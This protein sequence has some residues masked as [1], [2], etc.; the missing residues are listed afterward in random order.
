M[1]AAVW[2]LFGGF[3]VEGLD[4]YTALRRRCCWP[5]R[6][7]GPEAGPVA[8][9]VAETIRL[10]IGGGLAWA[11]ADSGQITSPIGA[12]AVG[13]AAP[14][15]VERLT[16]AVPLDDPAAIGSQQD[17]ISSAP[18][19]TSIRHANSVDSKDPPLPVRAAE[20]SQIQE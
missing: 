16:R 12:L 3:A 6:A 19:A 17:R 11:A 15:I 7:S 10:I 20:E 8:Y 2:G 13:V 14:V 4:L 1:Y 9:A 5:W 18:P